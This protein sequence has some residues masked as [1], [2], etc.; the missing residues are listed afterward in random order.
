MQ[1]TDKNNGN[2]SIVTAIYRVLEGEIRGDWSEVTQSSL[3][4]GLQEA[5]K[6]K[7]AN[8][9]I[10]L[11]TFFRGDSKQQ[12]RYLCASENV[13]D[14]SDHYLIEKPSENSHLSS[15][16]AEACK[17]A[18]NN[19]LLNLSGVGRAGV[20]P[21][22]ATD[23]EDREKEISKFFRNSNTF[24]ID[25]NDERSYFQPADG[26]IRLLCANNNFVVQA[27]ANKKSLLTCHAE[28]GLSRFERFLFTYCLF[29][30]YRQSLESRLKEM[31]LLLQTDES[32]ENKPEESY[33]ELRLNYER[34]LR[35]DMLHYFS[36]PVLPEHQEV[37]GV[38]QFFSQALDITSIYEE[39]SNQLHRL[40]SFVTHR[41]SEV[42]ERREQER[43]TQAEE[44]SRSTR[45]L[46]KILAAL[47]ALLVAVLEVVVANS[48]E[49]VIKNLGAWYQETLDTVTSLKTIFP[50]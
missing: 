42:R 4:P 30:A 16:L 47:L 43:E 5:T 48:P 39:A 40:G 44:R 49:S 2:S 37:H 6:V 9:G 3:L 31:Y 21:I 50:F 10:L 29:D 26:G 13:N 36:N 19:Q 45:R 22:E 7:R 17:T 8:N 23:G 20:L 28:N 14:L 32:R 35:F 15:Q 41:L 18:C 1:T 34:H 25:S 38:A 27:T 24:T 46:A 11:F 33:E 12:T